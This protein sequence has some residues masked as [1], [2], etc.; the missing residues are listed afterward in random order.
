MITSARKEQVE[1][2]D[3]IKFAILET[4]VQI[5]IIPKPKPAES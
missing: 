3:E 2:L 4:S 5:S 1:R